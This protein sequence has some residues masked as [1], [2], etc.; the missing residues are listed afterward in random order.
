MDIIVG[1]KIFAYIYDSIQIIVFLI[2][3]RNY[4]K[5]RK[6]MFSIANNGCPTCHSKTLFYSGYY[7]E[8]Y[9]D[10]H[11]DLQTRG[12][13]RL[14]VSCS[15]C[16][17]ILFDSKGGSIGKGDNFETVQSNQ[18]LDQMLSRLKIHTYF[19]LNLLLLFLGGFVSWGLTFSFIL[20]F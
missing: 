4:V 5:D 17:R 15:N 1:E 18:I 11:D 9:Y 8:T 13:G 14:Y 19:F 3:I 12:K 2:S 20:G 16:G 7:T 6:Q 10:K